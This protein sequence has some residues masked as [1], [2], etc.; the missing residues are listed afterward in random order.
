MEMRLRARGN[1]NPE[2]LDDSCALIVEE[3][4]RLA[5]R[6]GPGIPVAT[7][8]IPRSF[9]F[10]RAFVR[11]RQAGQRRIRRC[12]V[13]MCFLYRGATDDQREQPKP[14]GS[15]HLAPL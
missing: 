5:G 3:R 14:N 6:D 7:L 15:N 10:G 9:V 4:E 11:K 8:A 12:A 13:V 2:P 1:C